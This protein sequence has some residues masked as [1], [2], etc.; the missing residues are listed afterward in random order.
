[1]KINVWFGITLLFLILAGCSPEKEQSSISLNQPWQFYPGDHIRYPGT[2]F[3]DTTRA[4]ISPSKPWERQGFKNLDGYAWYRCTVM[5]PSSLKQQGYFHDTLQISLGKIDDCDQVFLNGK[6]IGENGMTVY[7]ERDPDTSFAE[8]YGFWDK[9]RHYLLSVN[10]PRI[11]WDEENTIAIRVYDSGGL[12]GLFDGPFE[13]SMLDLEDYIHFDAASA[14]FDYGPG[15]CLTKNFTIEN[16]SSAEGFQGVLSMNVFNTRNRSCLFRKDT[17]VLLEPGSL[18]TFSF[19]IDNI[20]TSPVSAEVSFTE[21]ASGIPISGILDLPYILTPQVSVY[22]RINGARVFG[23]RPGSPFL[24]KVPATGK[25]PLS[26]FAENLPEG[27]NLHASTGIISGQVNEPGSYFCSLIVENSV[28]TAK[29]PFRIEVGDLISLTPPLGWNSWNCWGLSVSDEKVRSSALAMKESGLIDHGWS[30]INI[31]D[32]WEATHVDGKIATNEKFPDMHALCDY[33]HSLGLKIGIYSSPG[34]TTCGGYEGSYGFEQA[35]ADSYASWGMDY[36]KYD[37][38]SYFRIAPTP[39]QEE[40]EHPYRI[41]EKALL[42]TGRDIHYSLCQYGMGKVWKWGASVGGNSW[43]TTGD[44]TDTWESLSG[45]GFSQGACSQ[46]ANPGHWND[47]DMLVLGWVGWGPN[48]HYTQLTPNE[49]Y[50]HIT[51][52]S[53]LASPLLLGNDLSQL[54]PFTMNLL[55]ND[56]VLAVNQDPLGIQAIPV[57][58]ND[59]YQIWTKGMEDGSSVLGLFNL[60]EQS[61]NLGVNLQELGFGERYGIRDLWQQREL[62]KVER[63][64]EIR[65]EPHGARM[66]HLKKDMKDFVKQ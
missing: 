47:P 32:G 57:V 21:G 31:D 39:N 2:E 52:W 53:M 27:L 26:Y 49:Q 25:A 24:F 36:L 1:M 54:D 65:I 45:I 33:V 55:T 41:M 28:G 6:L 43:R 37:W 3:N 59:F 19:T 15:N 38:C 29:E 23:V 58:Q 11:R 60:T 22:P 20:P 30:Y 56:E 14:G 10:D 17:L 9:P 35:D 12:G 40:L 66:I 46:Y 34:P 13:L 5:I 7:D 16:R 51:L 64:F 18:N 62:G 44:I 63:Y 42:S 50:T 48:L 61:L 4:T 8:S